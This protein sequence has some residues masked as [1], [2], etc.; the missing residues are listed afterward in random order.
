MTI[1]DKIELMKILVTVQNE[2]LLIGNMEMYDD[3]DLTMSMLIT[4]ET[5]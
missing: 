1:K 2:A 5:T 3:I 4:S